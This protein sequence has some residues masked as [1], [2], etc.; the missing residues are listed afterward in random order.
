[1]ELRCLV[2]IAGLVLA[3]LFVLH[4]LRIPRSTAL[5]VSS[6]MPQLPSGPDTQ[7]LAAP[8]QTPKFQSSPDTPQLAAPAY[9]VPGDVTPISTVLNP[10]SEGLSLFTSTTMPKIDSAADALPRETASVS[11]SPRSP[12]QDAALAPT[13]S[14]DLAPADGNIG[15][16][17]HEP[18]SANHYCRHYG[19]FENKLD[20]DAA[21]ELVQASVAAQDRTI[22]FAAGT[23]DARNLYAMIGSIKSKLGK[24]YRSDL[25]KIY[26]WE[27]GRLNFERASRNLPKH[28]EVQISKHAISN[29]DGLVLNI[30]GKDET[31]GIYPAGARGIKGTSEQVTTRRYDSLALELSL[32]EVT[33]TE[34]DVEGHEVE[35]IYSMGLERH[36]EMFPVF[37]YELGG[38]WTDARHTGDLNQTGKVSWTQGGRRQR[39]GSAGSCWQEQAMASKG[40]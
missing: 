38:T 31:S 22:V 11:G 37:Q 13:A 6:K 25:L 35:A 21:N 28:P 3:A 40:H 34:I 33:F 16:P 15:W 27:I 36:P 32:S 30:S 18:R 2:R 29:V 20:F 24:K 26:G 14:P 17:P 9:D 4:N 12:F 1:M 23:N 10:A 19:S 7:Q 39:F 8:A 5:P